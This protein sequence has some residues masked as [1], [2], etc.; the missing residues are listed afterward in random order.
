MSDAHLDYHYSATCHTSD[1]AVLYCL[2]ALCQYAEKG[3]FPQIGWGGTKEKLWR[4]NGNQ[5]TVRFTTI[6]YRD[7]FLS[8]GNRLLKGQWK[9]INTNDNDPATPQR[10]K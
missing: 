8:E 7:A 3:N 1:L 5:F 10:R 4:K 6:E 2:R 9:L